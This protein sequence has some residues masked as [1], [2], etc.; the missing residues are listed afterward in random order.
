M[1][2]FMWVKFKELKMKILPSF[3]HSY[4][5]F[6]YEDILKNFIV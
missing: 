3:T 4:D 2:Y 6:S 5:L 1:T